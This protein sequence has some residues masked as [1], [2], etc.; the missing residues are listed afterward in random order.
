M[1]SLEKSKP[2]RINSAIVLLFALVYTDGSNSKKV[3]D[4]R[5]DP[6]KASKRLIN[7]VF[8]GL[9]TLIIIKLSKT[10]NTGKI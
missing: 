10:A 6:L 4:K 8:L 1:T 9:K 3:S 2:A 5:E 7:K